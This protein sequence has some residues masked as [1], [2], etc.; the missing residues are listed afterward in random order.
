MSEFTYLFRGRRSN[1]IAGAN[2]E[3]HGEVGGVVQGSRRERP[4]E[5]A[6]ASAGEHRK[7]HQRHPEDRERRPVRRGEGHR[8]RIHLLSR[9]GIS[10]HAAELAKACPIL[11]AGG[12]V[13]VRPIQKMNM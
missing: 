9:P 2:A 11:E 10:A 5:G 12:S 6:G 13:E 1:R 8:R 4:P 3:D 7:S